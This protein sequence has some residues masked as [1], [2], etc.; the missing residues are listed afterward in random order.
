MTGGILAVLP[1]KQYY[2]NRHQC[3]PHEWEV[4]NSLIQKESREHL[5]LHLLAEMDPLPTG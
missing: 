1:S 5:Y 4:L 2:V 3:R